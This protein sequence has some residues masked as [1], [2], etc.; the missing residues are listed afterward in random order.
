[1]IHEGLL[2]CK[3]CVFC[4]R[5]DSYYWWFTSR[6]I[7]TESH[8][9]ALKD[10]SA[11][12]EILNAI[13]SELTS[14]SF[15]DRIRAAKQARKEMDEMISGYLRPAVD[16]SNVDSTGED[17]DFFPAEYNAPV[18]SRGNSMSQV[19]LSGSGSG[20][21]GSSLTRRSSKSDRTRRHSG[22][23]E[24]SQVLDSPASTP[25]SLASG[26]SSLAGSLSGS[27]PSSGSGSLGSVRFSQFPSSLPALSAG[28]GSIQFASSLSQSQP[29]PMTQAQ[30]KAL[31]PPNQSSSACKMCGGSFNSLKTDRHHCA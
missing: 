9:Y 28:S 3:T 31:R 10:R 16:L 17:E 7:W 8:G 11:A 5:E 15:R 13:R 18:H 29:Q 20:S 26:A 14:S 12:I 1:M 27:G 25:G 24:Q 21:R 2:I 30:L 4:S 23:A 6:P 19:S 22:S